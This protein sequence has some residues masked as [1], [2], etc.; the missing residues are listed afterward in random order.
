MAE[1]PKTPKN[2]NIKKLRPK[3]DG[4]EYAEYMQA[5]LRQANRFPDKPSRTH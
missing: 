3:E 5:V 4:D 1:I 2:L